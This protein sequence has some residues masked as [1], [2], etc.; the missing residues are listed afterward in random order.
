MVTYT[1]KQKILKFII[2]NKGDHSMLKISKTLKIDYK[3]I[4]QAIKDLNPKVY[5]KIKKGNSQLI[6]FGFGYDPEVLA[7]EEKRRE[8]ILKKNP[9]L[10]LIVQEV[11]EESYQFMIVLL[12]GSFAKEENTPSSDIDICIISDNKLKTKSLSE[13]LDLLTLKTELHE[14]TTEEFISMIEK[15]KKNL[16]N[17]IIKRNIILFGVENY[18]NLLSKWMKEE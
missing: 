13:R 11:N 15:K 16:G 1:T 10:K 17:E 2:E 14:F 5:S 9:K 3:N 7:V 12:F 6:S 18:Y 8:D 4:F